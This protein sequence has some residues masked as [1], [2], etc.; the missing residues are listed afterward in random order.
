MTEPESRINE[1]AARLTEI[2]GELEAEATGDERAAELA[3]EAARLTGEAADAV[4]GAMRAM[5]KV[6]DQ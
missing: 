3:A 2:V 5:S 1:I 4:E 6:E